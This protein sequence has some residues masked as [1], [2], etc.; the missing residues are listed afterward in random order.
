MQQE[1]NYI[2]EEKRKIYKA[3]D[4]QRIEQFEKQI[5]EDPYVRAWMKKLFI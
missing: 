1:G 3:R 4:K 2:T 5:K